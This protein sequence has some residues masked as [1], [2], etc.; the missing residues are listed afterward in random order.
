M[1][2]DELARRI[3]EFLAGDGEK[4]LGEIYAALRDYAFD[5]DRVRYRLLLLA[6]QGL[7]ERRAV[8]SRL[9][10]WKIT[11]KGKKFVETMKK[12]R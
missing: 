6:S 3:L 12:Q 4:P 5:R 7:V 1:G 2:L 10:L 11:E 8:T 9:S